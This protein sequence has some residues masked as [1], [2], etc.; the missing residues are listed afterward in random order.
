VHVLRQGR[1]VAGALLS[2]F[3][4]SAALLPATPAGATPRPATPATAG[5][6]AAT[7]GILLVPG[8]FAVEVDGFGFAGRTDEPGA[9]D[10]WGSFLPAFEFLEECFV[11]S[12]SPP[13]YLAI[14]RRAGGGALGGLVTNLTLYNGAGQTLDIPNSEM[15]GCGQQIGGPFL[16]DRYHLTSS[17][18][19]YANPAAVR[20]ADGSYDLFSRDGGTG[21]PFVRKYVAGHGWQGSAFIGGSL[22]SGPGALRMPDGS[23][24]MY[25]AGHD[26]ALSVGVVT[27]DRHYLGLTDVG[28]QIQGRPAAVLLP[29]RSVAVF[30]QGV[31]HLLYEAVWRPDGTFR[32]WINLGGPVQRTAAGPAA[33]STGGGRVTVVV[34]TLPAGMASRSYDP[35]TGWSRWQTLTGLGTGDLG[36]ASP[37]PGVV[38][39]YVRG[40]SRTRVRPLFTLRAVNGVWGTWVN[41]GGGIA[42]SDGG[43][44]AAYSGGGRTDVWLTGSNGLMYQR[45]RTGNTW[46]RWITMPPD[47]L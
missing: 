37:A 32:G 46:S 21:V 39:L 47:Q 11:E 16:T 27:R 9:E 7:P 24:R 45:F 17:L 6:A 13:V 33:A 28:G 42:D 34:N 18:V 10:T 30:V 26:L 23:A 12:G 31:N 22:Q 1:P 25:A 3:L 4:L 40:Y 2:A 36:A 35:A 19:G 43:P 29:D 5:P 38:D 8:E 44:F 41:L 15:R 20:A 14:T